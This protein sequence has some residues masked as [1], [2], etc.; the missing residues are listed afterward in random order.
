[1]P[2]KRV[3][4]GDALS[5][6]ADSFNAW[7][8]AAEDFRRRKGGQTTSPVS[9]SSD[10]LITIKNVS[11]YD[12]SRFD[13]LCI[14]STLYDPAT[15]LESYKN[16]QVYN[17]VTPVDASAGKFCILQEPIGNGSFGKAMIQ[18]VTP[19]KV[20]IISTADKFADV[21]N[22]SRARLKKHQ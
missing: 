17:A 10:S 20:N 14:S 2:L 11:G 21:D 1:M 12:C 9:A 3:K 13:V 16:T 4:P 8:D 5:I 6:P 19:C 18:G 7:T 22:N 15:A